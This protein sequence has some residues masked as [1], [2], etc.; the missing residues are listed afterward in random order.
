MSKVIL[1][2]ELSSTFGDLVEGVEICDERGRVLGYFTPAK[3]PRRHTKAVPSSDAKLEQIA[4][5]PGAAEYVP[6][7]ECSHET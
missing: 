3:A 6:E 2:P 4:A 7:A 5:D 1:N